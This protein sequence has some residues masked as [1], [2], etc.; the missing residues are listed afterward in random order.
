MQKLNTFCFYFEAK[1]F[2]MDPVTLFGIAT[3]S[4]IVGVS[5]LMSLK[6]LYRFLRRGRH[7]QELHPREL[8]IRIPIPE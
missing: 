1:R 8:R 3:A 2:K 7:R 6:W 5:I 4:T